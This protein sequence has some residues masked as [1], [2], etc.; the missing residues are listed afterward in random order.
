MLQARAVGLVNTSHPAWGAWIEIGVS[1]LVVHR[2]GGRT[3]YGVR[4]LKYLGRW[5]HQGS[6]VAPRMGCV[7]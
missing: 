3:P 2:D 7:D 5:T 1:R 4:G 6:R